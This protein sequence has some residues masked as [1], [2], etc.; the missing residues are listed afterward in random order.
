MSDPSA[1]SRPTNRLIDQTS[2]YL[3]QHAHNPVDWYPWGPEARQRARDEDKPIFLSIGYA[4]C[5]WCHVMERE[6]FENET[7]AR[8]MNEH[9]VNVKVDREERP[10]L[11]DVYMK[12]TQAISGQGGWPMSVWLTPDLE[13]FYAGT[14]FPPDARYGRAGFVQVLESLAR[15]WS[16]QRDKVVEQARRVAEHVGK[17]SLNGADGSLMLPVPAPDAARP[18]LDVV[19]QAARGLDQVFDRVHGGFGGAPKFPHADDVRLLLWHAAASGDPHALQM[20]EVTLDGMA[21]GGLYDQV[22]GGFARYSVDEEWS[23][24]HFEKML[25]DNGLLVPAYLEGWRMTGREDFLRVATETC[26]WVLR[27]MVDETGGL[28]STLDADS[29]GE[30]GKYYVWQRDEVHGIV[31]E[32]NAR[33]VD[34]A[35][36]LGGPPNFEGRAWH[37]RRPKRDAEL[38]RELGMD[39]EAMHAALAPL[40]AKL[41][42]ARER[43]VRP[44][45]DDKVLVAWNG[46]MIGALARTGAATGEA[47]FLEAAR[48]AADFCLGPTMRPDGRR[49]LATYR[50]GK[51]HVQATLA[52]HA[53]LAAGLLDLFEADGDARWPREALSLVE[54]A[55]AHF[56]DEEGAGFFFTSDDHEALITRP[57]DL[58]DGALPS[59]NGMM[60]EVLARLFELTGDDALRRVAERTLALVQP[61][62]TESPQAFA[63]ALLGLVRLEEGGAVVVAR[64]E[65]DE[66]LTRIARRHEN[67]TLSSFAVPAEGPDATTAD[68]FPLLAD[69]TARDGRAAAYVCEHGACRAPVT[70]GEAL[71]AQLR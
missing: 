15:S 18:R 49:L 31:G 63:R 52:D 44:G 51:A 13:P 36:G 34:V 58:F 50:R 1:T 14:Y 21:R 22:G 19:E 24:P 5:H 20:A 29:E 62:M 11:D 39:V 46:L 23:I 48:A 64:G 56:A 67:V 61:V 3:L 54:V 70:D 30:E 9:F 7:V 8:L 38:A 17:M 37:L 53:Y 43:R 42:E 57:R 33:L 41:Y 27:E 47:R 25:Y 26:E 16:T 45:T 68:L 28:W 32:E 10:D 69:K 60:V 4:A 40:K 2:P 66:A 65:G 55:Q 59:S 6:S 35:W 12:A 71:V